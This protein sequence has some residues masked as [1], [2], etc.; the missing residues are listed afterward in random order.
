MD[1]QSRN[2]T[3][4]TREQLL[5]YWRRR[6]VFAA[7]AGSLFG[8]TLLIAVFWPPSYRSTATILIEAQEIPQ[9]L[10]RSVITTYA[11]Q[12]VQMISQRVLTSQ[13]L[14]TLIDRYKLYADKRDRVPREEL[15][16]TMR[17]D[18]NL[19]MISASM[20]DPR[21]GQ[22]THA[23]I[24]FT[25]SYDSRSPDM[26]LKVTNELSSLY[27]NENLA[28]RAQRSQ[29]T[30][31]FFTE[32]AALQ[33][34]RIAELDQKLADFKKKHESELPEQVQQNLSLSDR[35]ELALQEAQDRISALDSQI[36]LLKSQLSQISPTAQVYKENGERVFG[37]ADQLKALKAKLAGLKGRY[38]PDHP[39]VI[40][41]ERQIE[42]L[43]K[44]V[45]SRD[46]GADLVRKLSEA[47]AQLAAASQKYSADHPDV[48][49][50]Q[51]EVKTLE[52]EVQAAPA[53][54]AEDV[55]QDHPDN[56][57]FVQIK[58]QLNALIPE[59]E[60]EVKKREELQGRLSELTRNLSSSPEVER[61]YREINRDLEAAQFQYGAI[62]AKQSEAQIAVNLETEQK[63]EKFTMIEAPQPP[64]KPVSPNRVLI[65]AIG[66]VLSLAAG[67][68]A[69]LGSEALDA[70]VRGPKDVRE[71]LQVAPLAAIPVVVTRRER[72]RRRR[73]V[74]YSWA[75]G[76]AA[77]ALAAVMVH[78]LV[79]PLDVLWLVLLRRF[80]V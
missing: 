44:E 18:I 6:K 30:A 68:A 74:R 50:L 77:V 63:G 52:G 29:Q 55:A 64:E 39:D 12:R 48:I 3:S 72:A 51:R 37:A 31:S 71:L 58:G 54:P 7:C 56:P 5:A 75:G 22:P 38:A 42:G 40:S 53:G 80:G 23:T 76:A 28:S 60:R 61:Q 8:A 57:A 49:R 27:L 66:L 78:F 32:E 26:A 36:V 2:S 59:R 67:V 11:D 33:Q 17:D 65:L 1:A 47:R 24:A 13:N 9:D 79:A 73:V 15:L 46:E 4:D 43:E 70:S 20:I 45:A 62:L 41:T 21:S 14:M 69:V 35:T 16:E 19:K 25:V 10:V 34:Q